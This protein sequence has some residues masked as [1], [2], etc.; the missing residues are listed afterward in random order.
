[1]PLNAVL[2]SIKAHFEH[3]LQGILTERQYSLQ[4]AMHYSIAN[5]GKRIR[6]LLSYL[7]GDLLGIERTA[8]DPAALA[9]ELVHCYSLVHDDLPAMDDDDLRRGK[10]TCHIQY[11]EATAI[12]VGDALQSLAFELIS[13]ATQLSA[14]TRIR[15]VEILSQAIGANGMCLG[16]ALDMEAEGQ[17]Q[18]SLEQLKQ[19]HHHKT[20]QLITASCELAALIAHHD[21]DD[22]FNQCSQLGNLLGV[23]F[24]IKD[25]VLDATSTTDVLGKPQGSDEKNNKLTYCRFYT[26]DELN[27]LLDD[28][29]QQCLDL[30]H[31]LHP[32]P[33][34]LIS[35]IN[36]IF[37]RTY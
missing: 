27:Q 29:N 28:M 22:V 2:T 23:A 21:G 5:G 12:L 6:P 36:Y 26:L 37:Q 17:S 30:A 35:V 14:D 10:P 20:G 11:D 3:Q 15:A 4:Q 13:Q 9:L 16:Q 25:D 33:E 34:A 7:I 1:M 24:Q 19:I 31:Q 18:H 32:N 8:I